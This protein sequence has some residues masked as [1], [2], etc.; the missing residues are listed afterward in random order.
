MEDLQTEEKY[1]MKELFYIPS[2]VISRIGSPINN[3]L[4]LTNK[5]IEF[6]FA[7]YAFETEIIKIQLADKSQVL[8]ELNVLRDQIKQI[9]AK[10]DQNLSALKEKQEKHKELKK[11]FE[12]MPEKK[13]KNLNLQ[14]NDEV[15][16][17]CSKDCA[18]F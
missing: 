8:Q 2:S 6:S 11:M 13:Q 14:K 4:E 9:N 10:L 3:Y 7:D 18:I 15:N 12:A 17:S 1:A 16:C 5:S